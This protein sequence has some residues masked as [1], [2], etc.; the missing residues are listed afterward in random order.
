MARAAIPIPPPTV[1]DTRQE[2]IS[3]L[4][5]TCGNP[6][7][8]W[9]AYF[10]FDALDLPDGMVFVHVPRYRRSSARVAAAARSL[11]CRI[12]VSIQRMGT[13]SGPCEEFVRAPLL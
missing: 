8:L 4:R 1:G 12:G 3:A 6:A 10:D 7:C 9:S 5:V 11:S 2:G 13:A